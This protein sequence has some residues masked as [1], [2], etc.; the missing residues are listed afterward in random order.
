MGEDAK[1][2]VYMC[3]SHNRFYLN[4]LRLLMA[5]VRLNVSNL[6]KYTFLVMTSAD[7]KD[8]V[9][10]IS[11]LV[12]IPIRVHVFDIQSVFHSAAAKCRIYEYPAIDEF[13]QVLYLDTDI[14]I[15]KDFGDIFTDLPTE[16]KVYGIEDGILS[17][18]GNGGWYFTPDICQT[19]ET[20]PAINTGVLAFRN[21]PTMRSV[22]EECC[23]FMFS[24]EKKGGDMPCCLEQPFINFVFYKRGC[25]DSQ[26]IKRFVTL[27][28]PRTG[29]PVNHII[30]FFAR[31]GDGKGKFKRM[32]TYLSEKYE[33]S[34]VIKRITSPINDKSF[35]WVRGSEKYITFHD[36]E[37]V[38]TP[39]GRGEY[40]WR[41]AGGDAVALM[42][43]FGG[44]SH[45][46]QF[47]DSSSYITVRIG[48]CNV[49]SGTQK[50]KTP[51]EDE[52]D[53]HDT[54]KQLMLSDI[55]ELVM[56]SGVLLEGNAFYKHA[57]LNEWD[58]LYSKQVNLFWCGKQVK[59]RI[60]E[61]G[62][63]AGHSAMLML[64]GRDKTELDFTIFDIGWHPYTK[65]CMDYIKS[66]YP[67]VKFT[68][69]EGDSTKTMPMWIEGNEASYD[70]IHVDGGHDKHCITND[71]KNADVLLKH[72]GIMI[73]DDTYTSI[74]NDQVELYIATKGYCEVELLKT[75][76]YTHRIIMKLV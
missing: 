14:L 11:A 35:E 70:V 52:Y 36:N 73:V 27:G 17:H 74:I 61:I 39:W 15:E 32:C 26:Y 25:L 20:T 5:T 1:T 51:V 30:H 66:K 13:S 24:E 76:G 44:F 72:G 34:L 19:P 37:T 38:V 18:P 28:E 48:D 46:W 7:F 67:H 23:D 68:Y 62:F 41:Y 53:S 33:K 43:K 54:E 21:T 63:N 31:I 57:T 49:V 65:P 4:L 12:G 40:S 60:C 10:A 71:M 8:E 69:I 56:Q 6:D 2:L 22:F 3:V 64:M 75:Q 45:Y 47:L 29:D 50:K 55:K 42:V 16:D 58:A 9:D 59:T